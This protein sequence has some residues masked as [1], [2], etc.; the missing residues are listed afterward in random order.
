M[1]RVGLQ[2]LTLCLVLTHAVQA[3]D[4]GRHFETKVKFSA[5]AAEDAEL[6]DAIRVLI[7]R[8]YLPKL[9][10]QWEASK[11][12]VATP[13]ATKLLKKAQKMAEM[14]LKKHE[15]GIPFHFDRAHQARGQDPLVWEVRMI[16][17]Q[18]GPGNFHAPQRIRPVHP[19][20]KISEEVLMGLEVR[21][22]RVDMHQMKV[23]PIS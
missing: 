15:P 14:F 10:N 12:E 21:T 8:G 5:Q 7:D 19:G 11:L 22:L 1:I 20:K 6:K 17:N 16:S 3:Q 9:V 4:L 18:G 2:L 13:D 23:T